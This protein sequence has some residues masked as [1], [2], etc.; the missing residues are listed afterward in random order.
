M[1]VAERHPDR[2]TIELN[3]LATR[4]LFDEENRAVGVEYLKGARLYRAH[5]APSAET[6]ELRRAS[7]AREVIVAGG[8]FN[9]PQLLML[10]G[11]GPPDELHA[12]GI[13]VRVPLHGVG[14]N[15]QDRYEVGVVNRMKFPCWEV[16]KDA[17]FSRG[18]PQYTD[19]KDNRRGVYATN[20]VVLA[21]TRKS[22]PGRPLPD[23][24]LLGLLGD[25]RGYFPGY[26]KALPK[27]LNYLTWAVLKAHT[28]N[29]DGRVQLRSADPRDT[30]L[31]NFHYFEEGNDTS[32]A[33]LAGVV[34]GIKFAR[35]LAG[36]I[37][38]LIAEEELPGP[39]VRSDAELRDFVRANAW[40]HHASCS[41]P[42][43]PRERDG[44]LN[45]NLE[46]HGTKHLRVVDASVF[47]RIPGFFIATSVYM[48]GEKASDVIL[49]EAARTP[50]REAVA[51]AEVAA[52]R[53]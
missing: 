52:A 32:G 12:H 16:L 49:R 31:I 48:V 39:D 38:D 14:R 53:T 21:V 45:S 17:T 15:L 13:G 36:P 27:G 22:D 29:S 37:S 3:A 41:C 30:P 26:S 24:F 40:G 9:T 33:D 6:G 35:R 50:R 44:V 51:D 8:A 46:V 2:L 4:V 5:A 23:L 10:S 43:G 34:E 20:G 47:P 42:I 1:G 28:K 25:F 18:D 11:I 7:V 19:W